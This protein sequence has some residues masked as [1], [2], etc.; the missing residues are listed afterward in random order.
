M[1][2]KIGDLVKYSMC[3]IRP[4]YGF[5]ILIIEKKEEYQQNLYMLNL[6]DK[7]NRKR[8]HTT[9]YNNK[10]GFLFA[11]RELENINERQTND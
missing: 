10:I 1:K 3:S 8:F 11:E 9:K 6:F 2:F 4:I 7:E 5:V